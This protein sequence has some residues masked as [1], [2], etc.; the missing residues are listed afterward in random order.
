MD[1][2]GNLAE[3]CLISMC[4]CSVAGFCEHLVSALNRIITSWLFFTVIRLENST[5]VYNS[6]HEAVMP[7]KK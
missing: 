2:I 6:N 3:L 7:G 4:N 5:E 1:S